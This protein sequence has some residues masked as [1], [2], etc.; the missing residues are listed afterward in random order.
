MLKSL[1]YLWRIYWIQ[2]TSVSSLNRT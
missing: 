2:R 1:E